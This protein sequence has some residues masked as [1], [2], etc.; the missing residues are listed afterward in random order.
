MT[1]SQGW[2][3]G[4]LPFLAVGRV[5]DGVT[6]AYSIGTDIKE[7]QE[8]T[9]DVFRKLLKVSATKLSPGQRTRLQWNDGSVCCVMDQQGYLLYCVVTATL[10][11]PERLAYQLL[12]DL[13]KKVKSIKGI[14]DASEN[15]LNEPLEDSM[16]SLVTQYEDPKGFPQLA[17]AISTGDAGRAN[18]VVQPY[19]E[20]REIQEGNSRKVKMI[21]AVSVIVFIII[22]LSQSGS[23]SGDTEPG[24][25]G[26]AD[27]Q[28][29]A[30]AIFF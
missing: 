13:E 14:D 30:T 9:Q 17:S 1:A 11:Y 26:G 5:K 16:R 28:P 21:I 18:H 10:N 24:G 19:D 15:S 3:D 4:A 27:P 12:Y 25:G 22:L 6:L 20:A 23:S 29:N 8:Q 7:Q 2:G